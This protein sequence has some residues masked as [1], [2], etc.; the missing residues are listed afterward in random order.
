MY[1]KRLLSAAT[2]HVHAPCMLAIVIDTPFLKGSVFKEGTVRM[3]WD[4]DEI[5]GTNCMQLLV[6][7]MLASKDLPVS[8]VNLPH[9]RKPAN[10]VVA[11][12]LKWSLSTIVKDGRQP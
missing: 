3:M 10:A 5:D 7:W 8:T 4:S 1:L 2:V 11:D 12:A 9:L 6:R